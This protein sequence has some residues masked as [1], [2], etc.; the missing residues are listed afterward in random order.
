VSR[1]QALSAV[2]V[3]FALMDQA[4]KRSFMPPRPAPRQI[5]R[6]DWTKTHGKTFA[7]LAGFC[8]SEA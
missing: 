2:D 3:L 5:N 7:V 8:H 4:Q 6:L 1:N